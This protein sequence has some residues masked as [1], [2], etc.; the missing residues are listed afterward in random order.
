MDRNKSIDELIH[1]ARMLS[2]QG[3]HKEAIDMWF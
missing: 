2:F 3:K 1:D